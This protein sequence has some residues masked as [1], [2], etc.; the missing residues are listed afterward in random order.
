MQNKYHKNCITGNCLWYAVLQKS[1]QKCIERNKKEFSSIWY[2]K[3]ITLPI[4]VDVFGFFCVVLN[5][6]Q[7][8][9]LLLCSIFGYLKDQF[10]NTGKRNIHF[11]CFPIKKAEQVWTF[12]KRIIKL[13][14]L[15]RTKKWVHLC[16]CFLWVYFWLQITF[17]TYT[18]SNAASIDWNRK[19]AASHWNLKIQL[20][21]WM[22]RKYYLALVL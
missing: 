1:M 3:L 11:V 8:L 22:H 9:W 12:E 7:I 18:K 2:C 5:S 20:Y 21:C 17:G 13:I 15:K 6:C 10:Q 16:I 4:L 14:S 19:K